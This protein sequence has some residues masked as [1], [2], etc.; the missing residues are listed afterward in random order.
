MNEAT[1]IDTSSIQRIN[2]SNSNHFVSSSFPFHLQHSQIAINA[3]D[4]ANNNANNINQD[5]SEFFGIE[6]FYNENNNNYDDELINPIIQQLQNNSGV[7]I[8]TLILN[9]NSVINNEKNGLISDLNTFSNNTK[10]FKE[11]YTSQY[12]KKKQELENSYKSKFLNGIKDKLSDDQ[13]IEIEFSDNKIEKCDLKDLIKYPYSKLST[14]FT[15]LENIPKRNNHYFLDRNHETFLQILD[16]IKTEKI[17]NFTKKS[18]KKKFLDEL[19]Y[20][21]INIKIEQKENLIF[22]KNYCP[23]YFILN[24]NNNILQ[25]GN[26]F[27]GIVLIKRQLNYNNPYIEFYISIG[28]LYNNHK[29]YFALVDASKFK[30][31]YVNSS[32]NKNVPFVFLWD[33][34]GN[35]LFKPNGEKTK[36]MDLSKECKCYL[37]FNV[38]KFGLK[39]NHFE[40]SIELFR[41]DINLGVE[42]KNI[43]PFLTPAI[44]INA[45]ECKIQLLNNNDQ[46]SKI[47]I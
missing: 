13:T 45:E 18:G 43:Q 26:H 11:D 41:N 40:N 21:G 8:D 44:E 6:E 39:Y 47:F 10:N 35:K 2:S 34:F 12:K 25:K 14:Y 37:N 30:S 36:S 16:F 29:I 7:T 28:N 1:V 24:K 33:I 19:S 5:D 31:K 23:K 27:S 15:S 22:D 17:P 20:W 38:T 46:Q 9:L 3:E 4:S 42:V 32:F